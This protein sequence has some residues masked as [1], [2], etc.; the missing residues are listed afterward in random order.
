MTEW[1]VQLVESMGYGGVLLLMFAEKNP[2]M[3]RVLIGDALVN[4]D[5]R[6]QLRISRLEPDKRR[7]GFT[8]RWGTDAASRPA[9]GEE[10]GEARRL[11]CKAGI[12]P[13]VLDGASMPLDLGRERRLFSK[14]QKIALD[15]QYHGCAADGCPGSGRSAPAR[16][17][18][19][20]WRR[21]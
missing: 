8:Q 6:L 14:H 1:L 11:A 16:R 19:G 7:V 21:A 2:G 9:E 12:I 4:E 3:T 10:G 18:E 17:S 13:M 5:D 15:H 20:A